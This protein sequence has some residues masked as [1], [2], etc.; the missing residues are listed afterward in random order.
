MRS[1]IEPRQDYI[2]LPGPSDDAGICRTKLEIN[3]LKTTEH[4]QIFLTLEQS[5][6]VCHYWFNLSS[7]FSKNSTSTLLTLNGKSKFNFPFSGILNLKIEL[8]NIEKPSL[9]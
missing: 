9:S 2:Q 3:Y 7:D 8:R 1:K 5:I 4:I 6:Q